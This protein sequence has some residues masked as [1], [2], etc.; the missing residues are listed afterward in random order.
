MAML[1]DTLILF[2][3]RD[4]FISLLECLAILNVLIRSFK[5]QGHDLPSS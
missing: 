1:L 3:K 4:I 5:L 2:L